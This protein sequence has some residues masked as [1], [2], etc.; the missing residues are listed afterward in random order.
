M[1]RRA[2]PVLGGGGLDA[3]RRS[4]SVT[5]M[6]FLYECATQN[7][8]RLKVVAERLGLTVQAASH[9]YRELARRGFVEVRDR[10]YRLTVPGVAELQGTLSALGEEI[11]RRLERL[12][13]VRTTLALAKRSIRVG[14]AV[15]LELVGGVLTATPN[16]RGG[17]RGRAGNSVRA[18]ELVEV[19]ELEGIVPITP[20]SIAIWVVPR[21]SVA[22]AAV[23]RQ[24]AS[25]LRRSGSR[26]LVAQGIEAVHL[27]GRATREP[28]TRF[29]AAPA[30]LEASRLGVDCLVFVAEDELPRF[31]APFS[32]PRPLPVTVTRLG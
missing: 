8:P 21:G 23:V 15:G 2:S 27:L 1:V 5:E 26:L 30:C 32:G 18:G 20:G 4:G 22:S 7:V 24:A 16:G 13:I 10:H 17:S 14:Q 12:Q 25:V 3:L 31:L 19:R 11:G 6:L 9:L 28:V 29:G